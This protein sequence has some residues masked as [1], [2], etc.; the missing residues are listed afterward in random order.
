MMTL[1]PWRRLPNGHHP[2]SFSELR[3]EMDR[4]LTPTLGGCASAGPETRLDVAETEEAIRVRI[5]VPGVDPAEL[6]IQ[7]NGDL[8][9]ISGEKLEPE[10]EPETEAEGETSGRHYSE[11]RFGAFERKVRLSSPVDLETVSAEHEHGV[12]TIT[13]PLAAAARPRRIEVK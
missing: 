6:E 9:T 5:E 2:A 11:R 8:L 7:V 4:F 12:V 1:T 10:A 3:R 13:L